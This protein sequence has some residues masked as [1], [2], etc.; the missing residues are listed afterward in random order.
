MKSIKIKES[1]ANDERMKLVNDMI[2]GIRTIKCYAWELHYIKKLRE[3]RK[4]QLK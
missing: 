2:V 4:R 1:L 3:I